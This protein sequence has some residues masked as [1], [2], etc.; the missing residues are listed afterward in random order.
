MKQCV[1]FYGVVLRDNFNLAPFTL[2]LY[3]TYGTNECYF[4]SDIPVAYRR[5]AVISSY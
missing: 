4:L 5:T 2:A 1:R 3:D